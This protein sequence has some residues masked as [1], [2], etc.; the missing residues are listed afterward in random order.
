MYA[1]ISRSEEPI[2]P[3]RLQRLNGGIRVSFSGRANRLTE[4][5]QA[6]PCRVLLPRR[7]KGQVEAVL[8]NTAGGIT[9]GDQLD[10]TIAAHDGACVTATTQAAEKVY[11]S[12]GGDSHVHSHLNITGG[13]FLE[14]LPQESILFNGGALARKTDIEIS[15]DSRL[16]AL[17]WLVLGRLASGETLDRAAVHD[18]WRLRRDGVLIWADDFR[19]AGDLEALRHRPSLLDGA[20]ALA[21]LIYVADDAPDHLEAVRE[22]LSASI[23]RAGVSERPGLLICRFLGPDGFVLRRDVEKFLLS[24][25]T[26]IHGRPYPLPRVWAC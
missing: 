20:R 26:I 25:R 7:P 12:R 4:L 16:L 13:G 2:P 14:W 10:Y 18:R 1:A 22:M 15:G 23:S 24:F 17:D 21:T 6:N 8:L 19:L 3:Q 11:R 9:D 5:Y